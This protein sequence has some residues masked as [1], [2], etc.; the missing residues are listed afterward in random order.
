MRT[1]PKQGG[2]LPPGLS[3]EKPAKNLAS[4]AT[5]EPLRELRGTVLAQWQF[6]EQFESLAKYGIRPIDRMLFYGPPGNGKTMACGWLAQQ[7]DAPL[8][9]VRCEALVQSLVGGTAS[10]ISS[11]MQW[12]QRQD[13]CVVLFDE[14]EQI[15]MSRNSSGTDTVQRELGSAMTVFWQFLDRWEAPTLFVLA[16]NLPDRLDDALLSRIDLQME[17]GPPTAEQAESVIQYWQETLHEYGSE[18]WGPELAHRCTEGFESFRALFQEI[19]RRVRS[20][21]TGGKP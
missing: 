3:E 1:L 11:V 2:D 17:F 13:R 19:Q 14:V 12:L 5:T 20:H 7:I 10:N 15:L 21:V 4:L 8:F 16:T 18:T 9:R 6:T